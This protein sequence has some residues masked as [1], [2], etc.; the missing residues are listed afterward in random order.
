MQVLAMQ[1]DNNYNQICSNNSSNIL[2]SDTLANDVYIELPTSS[3]KLALTTDIAIVDTSIIST[4][5][6]VN[7]KTIYSK[8]L[9]TC[10]N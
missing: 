9:L 6:Y 2:A 7:Y 5:A 8:D 10:E 1:T 4:K 3:G